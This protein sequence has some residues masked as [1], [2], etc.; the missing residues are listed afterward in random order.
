MEV[1]V[2]QF[3][4]DA[5]H[6][7]KALFATFLGLLMAL[8]LESWRL[9]HYQQKVA[10]AAL[11]SVLQEMEG[12]RKALHDLATVNAGV[13]R[14]LGTM[15]GLLETLQDDRRQHHPWRP[16]EATMELT[17]HHTAGHLK[18]SA[19]D[20]ALADQSIHRFPKAQ[21][22]DLADFYQQMG[23]LQALL[24]QPVDYASY[25]AMS[26]FSVDFPLRKRLERF[27]DGELEHILWNLR[28]LKVRFELIGMWS[29]GLEKELEKKGFRGKVG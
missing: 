2:T 16:W 3:R 15:I 17:I 27:S 5:I 1:P 10:R 29:E 26:R 9:E 12:N 13:P 19:W 18:S 24:D 28:Q 11:E 6:F 4:E 23:R 8:G 7:C 25:D 14:N 21:A 22:A 20:M